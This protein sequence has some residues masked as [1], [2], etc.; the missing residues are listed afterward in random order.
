VFKGLFVVDVIIC[1]GG[2]VQV[3]SS[4]AGED[5]WESRYSRLLSHG[6]GESII[7]LGLYDKESLETGPWLGSEFA[8][9]AMDTNISSPQVGNILYGPVNGISAGVAMPA[10]ESLWYIGWAPDN[11]SSFWNV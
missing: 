2:S 6:A 9:V 4:R 8:A 10:M 3:S 5:L 7:A 1:G 11:S